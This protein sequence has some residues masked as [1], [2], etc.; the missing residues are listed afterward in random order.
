MMTILP[1]QTLAYDQNTPAQFVISAV[2]SY[3]RTFTVTTADGTLTIKFV[4]NPGQTVSPDGL[5]AGSRWA[6]V[7]NTGD[8]T[9][10]FTG[11][12]SSDPTPVVIQESNV[13]AMSPVITLST[14]PQDLVGGG[15]VPSTNPD[16]YVDVFLTAAL[17]A[18]E[19]TFNNNLAIKPY[20]PTAAGLTVSGPAGILIPGTGSV[21]KTYT[22]SGAVDQ[23]GN[24]IAAPSGDTYT[25]SLS[26]SMTGIS[27]NSAT[28]VVTVISSASENTFDVMVTGAP[29]GLTGKLT[30]GTIYPGGG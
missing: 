10:E 18:T 19:G 7:T 8:T 4:G 25:W 21:T 20:M 2:S 16:T 15:A 26:K 24:S 12:L 5:A 27:I 1:I 3:A 13:A 28:G 30:V 29:S 11:A 14:A 23:F 9:L 22:V 6:R 17:P